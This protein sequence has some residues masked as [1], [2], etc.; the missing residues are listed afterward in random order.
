M[1]LKK[2]LGEYVT[3][4]VGIGPNRFLAKTAAG[5]H[6][7]NGL[8]TITGHT[9][10]Q[11]FSKMELL[12]I[13]GI[14]IRYQARLNAAGIY[15]PLEFLA[16]PAEFLA[17]K[18][19]KSRVGYDWYAR[20]RGWEVDNVQWGTKSIGHQYALSKKTVNRRE[21][22]RILIK[23]C[24]KTGR[25]MR[26]NGYS[27]H[28]I[29]LWLRF[30]DYSSWAKSQHIKMELYATQDIYLHAHRLLNQATIKNPVTQMG[31]TVYGLTPN[32]PEQQNLFQG[33]SLDNHSI[34]DASDS[35]NDRYGDFTIMPGLM[36]GMED[37]ILDRI[38]FGSVKN[39]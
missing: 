20:L 3:V 18:V 25:R 24:E 14:N 21:L 31:V 36:T 29:H 34:A 17:K 11:I 12:E 7:P 4:N 39:M 33:S 16:A 22:A 5:L 15:T 26:T 9:I 27:A 10:E 13:T 38:A 23:L 32:R 30:A 8:D 19:F 2:S 35:I 37:L 6:K 1:I 28:G